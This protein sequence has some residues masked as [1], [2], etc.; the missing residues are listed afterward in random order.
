MAI[1]SVP[2][3][4]HSQPT[5][6]ISMLIKWFYLL[7]PSVFVC[8]CVCPWLFFS[9]LIF[10]AVFF[11]CRFLFLIWHKNVLE[12]T[13]WRIRIEIDLIWCWIEQCAM[14]FEM[15]LV[16]SPT[17]LDNWLHAYIYRCGRGS[18]HFKALELLVF[19]VEIGEAINAYY[20]FIMSLNCYESIFNWISMQNHC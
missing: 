15:Q 10:V 8:V 18:T 4:L 3:L 20:Y 19:V 14:C 16:D 12:Q 17:H 6:L 2:K 1:W 13:I 7:L 5:K 11:F 9:S